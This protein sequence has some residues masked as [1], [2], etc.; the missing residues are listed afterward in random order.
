MANTD[1]AA[2]QDETRTD[3]EYE[4]IADGGNRRNPVDPAKALLEDAAGL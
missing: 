4:T 2:T 1:A 3:D